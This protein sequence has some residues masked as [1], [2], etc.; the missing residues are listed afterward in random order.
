MYSIFLKV[1]EYAERV[2]NGVKERNPEEAVL[3]SGEILEKAVT[4]DTS[5]L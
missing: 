4:G 3:A 5:I 2:Y 1:Y